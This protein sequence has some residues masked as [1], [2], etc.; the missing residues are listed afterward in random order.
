M[1]NQCSALSVDSA[2][3][4]AIAGRYKNEPDQL[5]RILFDV[6][7]IASNAIPR[8]VAAVVS[9][10]TG[11]PEANIYSY[12]TFYAM[13]ST[14]PRGKY[15]IRMCKSAPC[16]VVGAAEVAA[17]IGDFLGIAPG[18]TTSDGFFPLNF[19]ECIGLCDTSPAIMVN[20]SVYTNLTPQAAVN[21]IQAYQKGGVK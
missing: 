3:I 8:D 13:F 18:E 19:C 15:V 5:M 4:A 17:A 12:I 14:K 1:Q 11:I 7:K 6:Q 9:G 20:D 21:L 16:H 2:Q 10:V